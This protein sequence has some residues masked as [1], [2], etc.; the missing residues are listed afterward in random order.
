MYVLRLNQLLVH[1]L[2]LF[3]FKDNSNVPPEGSS[4][5]L[6]EF[7]YETA[8]NKL[9][10]EAVRKGSADNVTVLLVSVRKL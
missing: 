1:D 5:S 10:S 8:C 4:K 7:R 3:S 9:A 6:E 2:S